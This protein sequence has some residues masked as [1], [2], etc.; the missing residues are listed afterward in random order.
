M[1]HSYRFGAVADNLARVCLFQL[2]RI[3]VSMR[4]LILC[5]ATF[6]AGA[7]AGF[8]LGPEEPIRRNQA[9][10]SVRED[11]EYRDRD[12]GEYADDGGE[13]S[14][15][16]ASSASNGSDPRVRANVRALTAQANRKLE[17]L[18]SGE[19]AE[20]LDAADGTISGTVVDG[21]GKAI[22]GVV[23]TA[24]P[25]TRPFD[26]VANSRA[27]RQR[28]HED[29]D[30]RT[31]AQEA[32]QGELWRRMARRSAT[33]DVNGKYEIRGLMDAQHTLTAFHQEHDVRPLNQ[34]GR[35]QP[36]AVV[37]FTAAPVVLTKVEVRM[38]D[39][40]LADHAWLRWSSP[41]GNGGEAWMKD[42]GKVRMPLGSCKVK[43]QTWLP[44]LM[45]SEEVER[46]NRE[47]GGGEPLVLK[48]V[49]RRVLT[50]RLKL[51][52][53]MAVPRTVEY[54]LRRVEG[55]AEIEPEEL[56]KDQSNRHAVSRS[57]G[58]AQWFDL[59]PGNYLIAAF[60]NKRRLIAHGIAEV[61][62]DGASEI[63]LPVEEPEAGTYVKVHLSGPDGGPVPGEVSFRVVTT[64]KGRQNTRKLDATQQG[65]TWL[66]YIDSLGENVD[67]TATMRVGT[68]DFGGATEEFSLRGGRTLSFR[69]DKP[70][71]LSVKL[72]R[73][74]GSGVEGSL[75]VALRGK[76]G[77]DAWKQVSPDGTCDLGGVQ[78][79]RYDLFLYVRRKGRNYPIY[80]RPMDLNS[81]DDEMKVVVPVL[82]TL[83]VRWVAKGNPR[84][85]VLRSKD[86]NLGW[87]RRDER[88]RGK[89]ATFELVAAGEY[90]V[91]CNRK[92]KNVRVPGPA[93]LQL[94]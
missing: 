42:S 48:L 47:G 71:K 68:R 40:T 90:Q 64:T 14:E 45:E 58:K 12:G 21:S 15:N 89:V 67:P 92:R 13:D 94:P 8:L 86:E 74:S 83:K 24:V 77:A 20:V 59:E 65:D 80:K 73:Y 78:P 55:N 41:A 39:G 1:H 91:E 32:I 10:E 43:A 53:G 52:E 72:E 75:Y 33:T 6:A 31:V 36:D 87:M 54:R 30:L 81:G 29:R 44:E 82:H 23:I 50:A 4:I 61:S 51:P 85:A 70:N 37:D 19:L 56:L 88:M 84:N 7:L 25:D 69:F 17:R 22:S 2:G 63:E 76:L 3:G 66:V 16:R 57:A 11:R 26:L 5:F 27:A 34:R 60:L 28:P 46:Q 9:R 35:V 62:A 49:A 38:P 18:E 79:G 93:E